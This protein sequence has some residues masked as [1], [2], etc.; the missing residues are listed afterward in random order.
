MAGVD[1]KH[2]Q[3]SKRSI[4]LSLFDLDSDV[5]EKTNVARQHPD[6][7]EQLEKVAEVARVDLGDGPRKG[8]NLRPVGQP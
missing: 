4:E 8:R 1:G 5:G 6:I 2:G 3:S 7:V